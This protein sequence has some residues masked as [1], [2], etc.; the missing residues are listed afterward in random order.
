[1][2]NQ[3]RPEVIV[4]GKRHYRDHSWYH[5]PICTVRMLQSYPDSIIELA[6][7]IV[8]KTERA[9]V[10]WRLRVLKRC[11]DLADP[12]DMANIKKWPDTEPEWVA[13]GLSRERR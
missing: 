2:I 8:D 10:G 1:M 3:P 9:D 11:V 6:S 7:L 5:C 4:N 12:A 13:A